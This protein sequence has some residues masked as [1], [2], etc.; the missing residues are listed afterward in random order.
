MSKFFSYTNIKEVFSKVGAALPGH[1]T[2][3]APQ[4]IVFAAI[5]KEDVEAGQAVKVSKTSDGAWQ[6]EKCALA[7]D[8]AG[9][10]L[11]DVH[12][13]RGVGNGQ[14]FI[15]EF[16]KGSTV[17]VMRNGYVWVPVED[18]TPTIAH[19]GTVYIR[20]AANASNT[21]IPV[22]GL[23]SA[24]VASETASLSGIKFTGNVGFP[25][26]GEQ[27]GTTVAGGLTGRTAEVKVELG[28]L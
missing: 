23:E 1:Q 24:S 26:T 12:A 8:F 10:V 2:V 18:A 25:L 15:Y 28:L 4:P 16:K 22:G 14:Q 27:N 3:L 9:I 17:S 6:V 20:I 11:A 5:A 13:Q 19:D 7:A 21:A